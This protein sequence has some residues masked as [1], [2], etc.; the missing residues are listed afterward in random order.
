M[1]DDFHV[2]LAKHIGFLWVMVESREVGSDIHILL[3]KLSL[4]CS[5]VHNVV[6]HIDE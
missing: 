5:T 1:T 4:S 6:L 2:D 3:P